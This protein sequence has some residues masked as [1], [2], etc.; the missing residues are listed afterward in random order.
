MGLAS[1][2]GAGTA[3]RVCVCVCAA[4]SWDCALWISAS[5]SPS[6]CLQASLDLQQVPEHVEL[7]D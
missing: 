1:A 6:S 3:V 4:L 7:R 5:F 2:L